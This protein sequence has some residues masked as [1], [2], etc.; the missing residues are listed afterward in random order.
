MR[1]IACAHARNPP[2]LAIMRVTASAIEE[3]TLDDDLPDE[4]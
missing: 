2:A 3:I 1:R 4:A